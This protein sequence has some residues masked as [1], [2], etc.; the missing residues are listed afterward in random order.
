MRFVAESYWSNGDRAAMQAAVRRTRRVAAARAPGEGRVRLVRC[1]LSPR[2]EL[3]SW[4]FEADSEAAVRS[5]GA[6]AGID[7]E[8]ISPAVEVWPIGRTSRGDR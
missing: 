8:R 2:D 3:C 6:L 5:V 7:L 1:L 4:L